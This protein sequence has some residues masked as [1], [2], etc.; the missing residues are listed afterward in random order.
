VLER[1]SIAAQNITQNAV[2]ALCLSVG[3]RMSG[4]GH[5]ELGAKFVENRAPKLGSEPRIAVGYEFRRQPVVFEDNFKENVS[6]FLGRDLG[7]NGSKM[8]H[9]AETID[10]NQDTSAVF[11][12]FRKTEDKIQT[13]GTPTVGWDR[14]GLQWSLRTGRGFDSLA[15]FAGTDVLA[16]PFI[17]VWPVIATR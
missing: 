1:S 5:G 2:D 7:R 6:S 13:D 4:G 3:L 11:G 15:D 16:H 10:E 12:V 17:L 9:F 8:Y 14:K